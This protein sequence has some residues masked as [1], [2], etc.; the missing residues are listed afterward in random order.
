MAI[1]CWMMPATWSTLTMDSSCPAHQRFKTY[2]HCL[3]LTDTSLQNLGFESSP[4]KLTPEFVEV[5]KK[6]KSKRK[7]LQIFRSWGGQEGTCLNTSKFSSYKVV[8][9]YV[10]LKT[11]VQLWYDRYCGCQET[12]GQVHQPGWHHE[13]WF[14]GIFLLI[15]II[16]RRLIGFW[17]QNVRIICIDQVSRA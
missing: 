14:P 16:C 7:T 3:V 1:S 4:F 11:E 2:F 13:D 15:R 6:L 17:T 5:K 9:K 12:S 10:A 8:A